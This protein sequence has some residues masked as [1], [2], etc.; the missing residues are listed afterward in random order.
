M[1]RY[2][3]RITADTPHT[4][5]GPADPATLV[6]TCARSWAVGRTAA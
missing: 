4:L 5:T 6:L 3:R 1:G 2:N